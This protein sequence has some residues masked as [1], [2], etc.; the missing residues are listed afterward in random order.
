MYYLDNAATT[1]PLPEVIE[2][3]EE[4]YSIQFGNPSSP[5]DAGI[6]ASH[7]VLEARKTLSSIF[8]VPLAGVIFCSSGSE[9]D[10]LALKGVFH[11]RDGFEGRVI[12]SKLEHAAV[13]NAADWLRRWG[14]EVV[15]VENCRETGKIDLQ[16]LAELITDETKIVSIQHIN[17]ETGITQNLAEISSII[18]VKNPSTLFHSDGVQAFTKIPVH[19]KELGV[20]LYSISA[21]KFHGIKGGG[22]LIMTKDIPLE[23]LIHGGGQE[24]GLRSGTENVAS[25]SAMGLA[26]DT[27][28]GTMEEDTQKVDLFLNRLK[29]E[30]REQCPDCRFFDF[31]HRAPHILSLSVP[32]IPGEILLNHLAQKGIFVSTG[33]ACNAADKK[34]SPVLQALGFSSRRIRET[35]R[36]SVTG[37]AL[38][39]K[40]DEVLRQIAKIINELKATL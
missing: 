15:E 24:R 3:L 1:R 37:R 13:K 38:P 4:W 2:K 30:L 9:S 32:G 10:N 29:S 19:L 11:P 36:I 39:E 21:H 40:Q 26:A 27:V 33:S 8:D 18:K 28:I 17:S 14:A 7:L 22:A 16:H 34:L 12:I 23:P 6:G 35:V 20:D 5:H 31:D 25:I